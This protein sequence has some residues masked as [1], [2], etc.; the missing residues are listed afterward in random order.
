M[1]WASVK[2]QL[3]QVDSVADNTLA[4]RHRSVVGFRASQFAKCDPDHRL[5]T[6]QYLARVVDLLVQNGW[7]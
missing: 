7:H 6:L 1:K 5:R 4:G 2:R 3:S